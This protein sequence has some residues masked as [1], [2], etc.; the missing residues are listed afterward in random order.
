MTRT[1]GPPALR[2]LVLLIGAFLC[3]AG[4]VLGQ[5]VP[6]RAAVLDQ[7]F[8]VDTARGDR[9]VAEV[10]VLRP[11]RIRVQVIWSG[12][13]RS[14]AL[15][16]N[17]PG[18]TGYYARRDGSSPLVVEFDVGQAHMRRG[19]DWKVAIVNFGGGTASGH[20]LIEYPGR[21]PVV[22]RPVEP[23]PPAEAAAPQSPEPVRT[24]LEDGTVETR[25]PNGTIRRQ[26]VGSCGYTI[27]RPDG[28][29]SMV[30]CEQV[31]REEI[32]DL[33]A[34]L[35]AR[36]DLDAVLNAVATNLLD[37]IKGAVNDEAAV[38]NYLTLEEGKNLQ[39]RIFLRLEA[40]S[41]LAR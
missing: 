2:G 28:T 41:L 34:D 12:S 1:S 23:R 8:R 33:P 40:L 19:R 32:P 22:L 5:R 38:N 16:L 30:Q 26:R 7:A 20:L 18:Q 25:Y 4:P 3:C 27:I 11:G 36:D 37:D 24:F 29:R 17:G 6:L 14:L 9:T 15:I 13:A 31:Q 21:Q 10:T 39:D 35:L